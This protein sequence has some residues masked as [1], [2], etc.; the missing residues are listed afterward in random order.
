M[1]K[2]LHI[3][4]DEK[5]INSANWSFEKAFVKCNTFIVFVFVYNKG[6]TK[7]PAVKKA[8]APKK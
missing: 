2:I 4:S 7:K 6:K 3:A 1:P 8:N 5:F